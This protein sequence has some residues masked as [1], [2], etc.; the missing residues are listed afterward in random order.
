MNESPMGKFQTVLKI[1]L[2]LGGHA[3]ADN[4]DQ[5]EHDLIQPGIRSCNI[6]S[7]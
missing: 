7:G 4:E 3:L 5:R 6:I 1:G 2:L